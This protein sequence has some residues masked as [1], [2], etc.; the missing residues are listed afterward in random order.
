[1]GYVDS[2]GV[3]ARMPTLSQCVKG[4]E[5]AG[6]GVKSTPGLFSSFL[7]NLPQIEDGPHDAATSE[8]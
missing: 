3:L 7:L 1:M 6:S 8:K 2:A 4:W 5:E